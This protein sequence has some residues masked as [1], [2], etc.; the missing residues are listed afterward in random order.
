MAEDNTDPDP[1]P[2]TRPAPDQA[3][4]GPSIVPVRMIKIGDSSEYAS[5]GIGNKPR[6]SIGATRMPDTNLLLLVSG[7]INA[8]P[9]YIRELGKPITSISRYRVQLDVDSGPPKGYALFKSSGTVPRVYGHPTHGFFES[10]IN[11]GEHFY[12]II[13]ND[14][15]GCH[16]ALCRFDVGLSKEFYKEKDSGPRDTHRPPSP[17]PDNGIDYS[18]LPE[19]VAGERVLWRY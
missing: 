16:C 3:T 14:T 4:E 10:T 17:G 19:S 12:R 15:D 2:T 5:D 7:A 13:I 6:K 8:N 1:A 18:Q 9:N 11:L